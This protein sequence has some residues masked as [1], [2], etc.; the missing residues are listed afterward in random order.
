MKRPA[1]AKACGCILESFGIID[2]TA[3]LRVVVASLR[4]MMLRVAL[5]ANAMV[6]IM[7]GEK[8]TLVLFESLHSTVESLHSTA[9]AQVKVE[10]LAIAGEVTLIQGEVN[11]YPFIPTVL[12]EDFIDD[13]LG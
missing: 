4:V 13:Y 7:V 9:Q 8:L 12:P 2:W 11:D 1:V 6:F 3:I 5:E 10:L